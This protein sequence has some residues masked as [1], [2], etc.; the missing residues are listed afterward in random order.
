M[1]INRILL[2]IIL[3]TTAFSC[4]DG[5][6]NIE[7]DGSIYK[8]DDLIGNKKMVNILYDLHLSESLS[9]YYKGNNR[10][11]QNGN[12]DKKTYFSSKDFYKDILDKYEISDSTL[13]TSI[14]YYSSFPKKYEKIYAQ[15]S[16]RIEMNLESVKAKNKLLEEKNKKFQKIIFLRFPYI[17]YPEK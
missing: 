14:L 9:H 2:L 12:K 1:K 3:I 16:E 13:S 17:R 8:P 5:K 6:S 11:N 10:K 15:V 7:Y 4:T